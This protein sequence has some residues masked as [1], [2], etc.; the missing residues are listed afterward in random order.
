MTLAKIWKYKKEKTLR[1]HEPAVICLALECH[2]TLEEV[3]PKHQIVTANP[4]WRAWKPTHKW[5]THV[6]AL[7]KVCHLPFGHR[8]EWKRRLER[9]KEAWDL[10]YVCGSTDE[11]KHQL[12]S[13]ARSHGWAQECSWAV[14]VPACGDQTHV[15]LA[16]D[17]QLTVVSGLQTC[18][19]VP[20]S[21]V[22]QLCFY[23]EIGTR[24]GKLCHR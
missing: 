23:G 20:I 21:E 10:A 17:I 7:R 11:R 18:L 4:K 6:L 8:E 9:A 2:H 13:G 22:S 1:A 19:R 24:R 3:K 5:T 16:V 14:L 15:W 12:L